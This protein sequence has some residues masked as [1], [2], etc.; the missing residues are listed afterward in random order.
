VCKSWTYTVEPALELAS[1]LAT[2]WWG[3]S[4]EESNVITILILGNVANN[5]LVASCSRHSSCVDVTIPDSCLT[6]ILS[7]Y[8]IIARLSQEKF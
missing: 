5:T 6:G 4:C 8:K 3:S 7:H 2:I 1:A